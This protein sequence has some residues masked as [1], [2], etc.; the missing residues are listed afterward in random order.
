[1]LAHDPMPLG[2]ATPALN[3]LNLLF[4]L[5]WFVLIVPVLV[6]YRLRAMMTRHTL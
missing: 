6:R 4:V 2:S 5:I 3:I 1:M